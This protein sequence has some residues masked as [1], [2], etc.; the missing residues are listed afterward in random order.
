M[1]E[2]EQAKKRKKVHKQ[3]H[4]RHRLRIPVQLVVVLVVLLVCIGGTFAWYTWLERA[5]GSKD[6]EV[7]DPYYLYLRDKSDTE[8]VRL[9]LDSLFAG[10][11]KNLYFCVSNGP[12]EKSGTIGEMGGGNFDYTMELVYTENVPLTFNLY[13]L[14]SF[15]DTAIAGG[16]TRLTAATDKTADRHRA[17]FGDNPV[18]DIVNKGKYVTYL[19]G[20]DGKQLH[21]E[22]GKDAAGKETYMSRYFRLEVTCT[23]DTFDQYRKETDMIYLLV[24]AEQPKPTKRDEQP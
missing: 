10:E 7:M 2:K 6:A 1:K 15:E 9:A 11:T 16:G 17:M 8:M 20:K 14:D 5:A 19:N 4:R 24:K 3:V 22:T 18:E 13:E 21:L 12:N 23:A